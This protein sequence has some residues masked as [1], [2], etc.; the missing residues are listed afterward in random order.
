MSVAS[1]VESDLDG[2]FSFRSLYEAYYSCRKRK[3]GTINTLRFEADLFGN[4]FQLEESLE[5]GFYEPSRSLCFVVTDPKLREVFAA[6][7]RDRVVHHLLVPR[8][9]AIWEPKFIFD[10]YA[11]RK[12]KGTHAAVERLQSFMARVSRGNR[13]PGWFLQLDIRG[14]FMSVDRGILFE[15]IQ[16]KLE[17]PLLL[18]LTARILFHD[19]T[20]DYFYKGVPGLLEKIPPH[21]TL[22][23]SGIN[24]GLP[25]GNLTSQFFANVYLNELDQFVKHQLKCRFYLRYMDDFI[26]LSED[27]EELLHWQEVIEEFLLKRLELQIKPGVIL[28]RVSEGS[29]FL[30]YIVR[31]QYKLVRHRVVENF[32]VKVV[33]TKRKMIQQKGIGKQKYLHLCLKQEQRNELRQMLASYLGHFQQ[34]DSWNLIQSLWEQYSWLGWIFRVGDDKKL[35]PLYE[36]AYVPLNLLSQYRWFK[37]RFSSYLIFFQV[38]KFCE[39]YEE[40]AERVSKLF[41]LKLEICKVRKIGRCGFPLKLLRLYKQRA[42]SLNLSWLVV[43]EEGYY[44]P[45]LKKRVITEM[46]FMDKPK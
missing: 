38:G 39:F 2:L 41:G 19:C 8:L 33:E 26:L 29:D 6:N 40:E 24:K 9:E 18:G 1:E 12:N 17:D 21:K 42:L 35:I 43:G 30:G 20:R 37:Q 46:V 22:F 5:Q 7:F 27:R 45:G 11:C 4:L 3:R 44:R 14:F 23:Q 34:A 32:H 13:I 10:S 36:P 25:I 16:G 28:K 15:L 31:P